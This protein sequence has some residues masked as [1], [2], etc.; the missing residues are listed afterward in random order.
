[1]SPFSANRKVTYYGNRTQFDIRTALFV[2]DKFH[3]SRE[4]LITKSYTSLSLSFV[5]KIMHE[6]GGRRNALCL[7]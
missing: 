2:P 3:Y 6:E 5:E 4:S 7:L 1:M